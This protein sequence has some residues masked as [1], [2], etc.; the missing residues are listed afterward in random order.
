MIKEIYSI[1][2]N[3]ATSFICIIL[4]SFLNFLNF[5]KIVDFNFGKDGGL[6]IRVI[7][8]IVLCFF[9]IN[10]CYKFSVL[11]MFL[12]FICGLLGYIIYFFLII[13]TISFI[14]YGDNRGFDVSGYFE[15]IIS[16]LISIVLIFFIK[17]II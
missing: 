10:L 2:K 6:L 7:L 12:G 16:F 11:N 1:K 4:I 3:I 9:Y 15:E 13:N 5:I 8:N 17:K 14:L